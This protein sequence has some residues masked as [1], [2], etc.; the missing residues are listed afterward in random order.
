MAWMAL[1][2][3]KRRL[4][5]SPSGVGPRKESEEARRKSTF[6]GT[7][8][9]EAVTRHE[10]VAQD[11]EERLRDFRGQRRQNGKCTRRRRSNQGEAGTH[12]G[13]H[14]SMWTRGCRKVTLHRAMRTRWKREP[15]LMNF[16]FDDGAG[17]KRVTS[18]ISAAQSLEL[19]S[20][21][22]FCHLHTKE[23]EASWRNILS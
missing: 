8:F 6:V 18:C 19:W 1:E 4:G 15:L 14:W 11:L 9:F 20:L 2:K 16:R 13:L 21:W 7:C 3:A 23:C 22:L 10:E 12:A 17:Q 5:R